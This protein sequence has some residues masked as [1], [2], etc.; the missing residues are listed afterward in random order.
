MSPRDTQPWIRP[1]SGC[2]KE[3]TALI[4]TL[5]TINTR[6]KVVNVQ[7]SPD[8]YGKSL[9]M[10]ILLEEE[11]ETSAAKSKICLQVDLVTLILF[12]RRGVQFVA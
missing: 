9:A 8:H 1:T 5:T 11:I 2:G 6:I 10:K 4:K 3:N 7:D 12:I